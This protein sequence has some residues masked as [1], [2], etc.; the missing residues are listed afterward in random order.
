[1]LTLIVIPSMLML[2]TPGDGPRRKWFGWLRRGR[3]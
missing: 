3:V 2:V 1:V